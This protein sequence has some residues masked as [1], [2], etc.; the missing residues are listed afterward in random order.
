MAGLLLGGAGGLALGGTGHDGDT[1]ERP[2][3]VG[4]PGAGGGDRD[5]DGPALG[6]PG[7]VPGQP[8]LAQGDGDA[9]QNS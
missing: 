5:G 6:G 2:A 1:R 8:P 9:G 3:L 4:F 7:V